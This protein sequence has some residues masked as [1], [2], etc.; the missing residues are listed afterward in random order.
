MRSINSHIQ[1]QSFQELHHTPLS[2]HIMKTG[3]FMN[4]ISAL[5]IGCQI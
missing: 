3:S 4:V 2:D 1:K 5:F